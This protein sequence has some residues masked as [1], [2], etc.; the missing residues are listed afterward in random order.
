MAP[1]RAALFLALCVLA[2]TSSPASAPETADPGNTV[3]SRPH[4]EDETSDP[5]NTPEYES[6]LDPYAP[7][8]FLDVPRC[9]VWIYTYDSLYGPWSEPHCH[10]LRP[11][12]EHAHML[13]GVDTTHCNPEDANDAMWQP[14]RLPSP[15]PGEESQ[16]SPTSLAGGPQGAADGGTHAGQNEESS[17]AAAWTRMPTALSRHAVTVDPTRLSS[18]DSTSPPPGAGT[19]W[20]RR[21][22]ERSSHRHRASR[23]R[24]KDDQIPLFGTS[25]R[26]RAHHFG[27]FAHPCMLVSALTSSGCSFARFAEAAQELGLPEDYWA[28]FYAQWNAA[29]LEGIQRV[30]DHIGCPALRVWD[31]DLKSFSTIVGLETH[32]DAWSDVVYEPPSATRPLGHY[33]PPDRSQLGL[34]FMLGRS[35]GIADGRHSTI[36]PS[37]KDTF[38]G[39]GGPSSTRGFACEINGKKRVFSHSDHGHIL[40]HSKKGALSYRCL[41]KAAAGGLGFIAKEEER[42]YDDTLLHLRRDSDLHVR[43]PLQMLNALHYP[44]LDRRLDTFERRGYADHIEVTG[45]AYMLGITVHVLSPGQNGTTVISSITPTGTDASTELHDR[46]AIYLWLSNCRDGHYSFLE[47]L[48]SEE[49][50]AARRKIVDARRVDLEQRRATFPT[51][52]P[53]V[54][55]PVAINTRGSRAARSVAPAQAD[56][57]TTRARASAGVGP[58]P[59]GRRIRGAAPA[60]ATRTTAEP[61]AAAPAATSP[62]TPP[63][64]ADTQSQGPFAKTP[65]EPP[66]T[67]TQAPFHATPDAAEPSAPPPKPAAAPSTSKASFTCAACKKTYQKAFYFSQH[68]V[69][70]HAADT[71]KD[72]PAG[73]QLRDLDARL[74]TPRPTRTPATPAKKAVQDDPLGEQATD[75]DAP[76]VTR[77]DVM[78]A[79]Q[80]HLAAFKDANAARREELA[81]LLLTAPWPRRIKTGAARAQVPNEF[82]EA[83]PLDEHVKLALLE[84]AR[85]GTVGRANRKLA[86]NGVLPVNAEV[87]GKLRAKYPQDAASIQPAHVDAA[88]LYNITLEAI[89][90]HIKSKSPTTGGGP[91]GWTY[92]KLQVLVKGGAAT[93]A[94]RE[95]LAAFINAIAHG[96]LDTARLR[97]LLTNAR[98]VALRKAAGA[99]DP[100]PIG[101]TS[102]FTAIATALVIASP[103][104]REATP[105][106]VGPTE[107][108]NGVPGGV[109]ALPNV[110]TAYAALNPG[111][112]IVKTDVENAFGSLKRQKAINCAEH[113]P[114]LAPLLNM[115]YRAPT[116]VTYTDQASGASVDINV[117]CGVT[118]GGP[119]GTLIFSTVLR[120]AVDDTCAKHPSVKMIG[121]ADDR[122]IMGP[123]SDAIAALET[124]E[125]AIALLGLKLQRRKTQLWAPTPTAAIGQACADAN[126]AYASDGIVV[127]S[128]PIGTASFVHGHLNKVLAEY[129]EH[130]GRVQV[131][132]ARGRAP[133]AQQLYKLI[134]LCLAP[135]KIAYLLR[136]LSAASTAA[137]ARQYDDAVHKAVTTLLG[138]KP[139]DARVDAST[140]SGARAKALAQL[141][142]V[143]GGLGITSAATVAADFRLG[144]LLLTAPLVA[145]ALGPGFDPATTGATVLPELFTLLSSPSVTNL[146]VQALKNR[147]PASFF[148]E[149]VKKGAHILAAARRPQQVKDVVGT[150]T[151]DA[152]AWLRS[153][154]GEGSSYLLAASRL[155]PDEFTALAR[156]RMAL[157]P[158]DDTPVSGACPHCAGRAIEPSGLHTLH[159]LEA[160]RD[161]PK[162]QRTKR[163]RYVKATIEA[164]FR[165]AASACGGAAAGSRVGRVE[166]NCNEYWRTR[167]DFV[168]PARH[169]DEP[170]ADIVIE[171]NEV[172]HLLDLV[173]VHPN[174]QNPAHKAASTI[175]S[176]AANVAAAEK[177]QLYKAR[178][179]VDASATPFVPFA[180][181]T[182]GRW[183]KAARNFA[184]SFIKSCIGKESDDF[185]ADDKLLYAR[186]LRCLLDSIDSA[187]ARHVARQLLGRP[188]SAPSSRS[189]TPPPPA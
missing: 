16:V 152:A 44:S 119:E 165:S 146:G 34:I 140:P 4:S 116:V 47:H 102:V 12:Q 133:H 136:T 142:A 97:P 117:T 40:N 112:V 151:E 139:G 124:Y 182:G 95:G 57:T 155:T 138:F 159:C 153:S 104:V 69:K 19:R 36:D 143:E 6:D 62:S 149:G 38:V 29:H 51:G 98:G 90:A 82:P 121:I 128:A 158:T 1:L 32:R 42:L 39:A 99:N 86:S 73:R 48:T 2:W 8:T 71:N 7:S 187:R 27:A 83:E 160:G 141:A 134:R 184:S 9:W 72:T 166:P 25:A 78:R 59:A 173:L 130:I 64:Q 172:T 28:P 5:D 168:P 118:Q 61:A 65:E 185:T 20:M 148:V 17:D 92:D 109:E 115:L 52:K 77:A 150:M 41:F 53:S 18:A 162:G 161:G 75:A 49:D 132:A 14:L 125:A 93:R 163:H 35:Q 108:G 63:A 178:F 15:L 33:T 156:T 87:E 129:V 170:R 169:A 188:S 180:I 181:E 11:C 175:H 171:S 131:A 100:R 58:A 123:P 111:H 96:E 144:N 157:P 79:M 43:F 147:A 3:A 186:T 80:A 120:Q 23:T 50:K 106:A 105:S 13:D 56:Q 81:Y 179:E 55:S 113:Y 177:V 46:S 30:F 137:H 114:P 31:K 110:L 103:D 94:A 183:H 107:L 84:L 189:S 154:G 21:G 37:A 122:Y 26:Y 126:I 24:R 85:N 101:I 174:V 89:L 88:Q 22:R 145:A 91:D 135:A 68:L 45:L 74:P 167:D 176:T 164:A 54:T 10:F 127:A 66:A 67:Q 70:E 60:A 76:R